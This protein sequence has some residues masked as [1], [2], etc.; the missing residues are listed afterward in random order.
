MWI[1]EVETGNAHD[2][3]RIDYGESELYCANQVSFM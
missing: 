1:S 2:V 3:L